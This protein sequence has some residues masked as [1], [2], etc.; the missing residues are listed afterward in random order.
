MFA[1]AL[2]SQKAFYRHCDK[3][4]SH[5]WFYFPSTQTW[6]GMRDKP[7]S[8]LLNFGTNSFYKELKAK[9]ERGEIVNPNGYFIESALRQHVKALYHKYA[10]PHGFDA[11]T[12]LKDVEDKPF[13]VQCRFAYFAA[14]RDLIR[15]QLPDLIDLRSH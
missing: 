11:K 5:V 2:F 10:E 9:A 7:L 6:D 15:Y 3:Q 12:S 8:R 4:L 13:E 1:N 14:V